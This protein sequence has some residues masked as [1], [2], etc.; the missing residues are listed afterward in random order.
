MTQRTYLVTGDAGFIGSHLTERLIRDGH[1][2]YAVDNLSTGRIDNRDW[3]YGEDGEMVNNFAFVAPHDP[4]SFR[5]GDITDEDF[6]EDAGCLE[7]VDVI[8]HQAALPSVARSVEEPQRITRVNVNGTLSLL[9]AASEAGVERLVFASSSSVY[10]NQD[11][12]RKYE[13]MPL[14]PESPYAASKAACEHY[15]RAYDELG[16]IE[17]VCLRYFNVFGPGQDPYSEYAAVIPTF[18]RQMLGEATAYTVNGDGGQSRDFTYVENVVEANLLAA[19]A[20]SENIRSHAYNVGCG[21]RYTL[22]ELMDA[23]DRYNDGPEMARRYGPE[24]EGDVRHSLANIGRAEVQLGYQPV[25]GFQEGIRRTVES[26]RF[27]TSTEE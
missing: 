24:R 21:R 17:T 10:G 5:K 6:W 16:K 7:D 22:E 19:G 14:G 27:V 1:F 15:C 25:V 9:E 8:F 20:P 18:I 26:L 3:M 12:F 11:E 13:G 4:G 23:I 2:V